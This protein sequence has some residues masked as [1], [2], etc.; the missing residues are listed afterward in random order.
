[1]PY[2]S[3]E[4]ASWQAQMAKII[5]KTHGR[6][7]DLRNFR[8]RLKENAKTV[9]GKQ[10]QSSKADFRSKPK[11]E[12]LPAESSGSSGSDSDSQG[13]GTDYPEPEEDS[14]Y[15]SEGPDVEMIKAYLYHQLPLHARRYVCGSLFT[16]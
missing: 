12:S 8:R 3:Y 16:S 9:G 15:P 7:K 14:N 13:S 1:M 6:D 2:L 5:R 11:P 4:S 10:A